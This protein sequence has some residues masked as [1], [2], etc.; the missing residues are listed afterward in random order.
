MSNSFSYPSSIVYTYQ[1]R[2]DHV[3][4]NLTFNLNRRQRLNAIYSTKSYSKLVSKTKS[5]IN[6]TSNKKGYYLDEFMNWVNFPLMASNTLFFSYLPVNCV[7]FGIKKDW[8]QLF[9]IPFGF[10]TEQIDNGLQ[11]LLVCRQCQFAM[12]KTQYLSGMCGM[13]SKWREEKKN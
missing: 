2:Y 8:T 3:L 7:A 12:L 4:E 13:L 1:K 11:I 6:K 5:Y 10:T 9:L